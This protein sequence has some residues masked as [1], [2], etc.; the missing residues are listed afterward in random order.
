MLQIQFLTT[1]DFWLNDM[2]DFDIEHSIQQTKQS[3]FERQPVRY[4]VYLKHIEYLESIIYK[5]QEKKK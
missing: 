4:D 5:L 2:I 1:Q 3:A